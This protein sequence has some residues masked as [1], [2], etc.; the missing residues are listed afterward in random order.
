MLQLS[1]TGSQAKK[2][3]KGSRERV[4]NVGESTTLLT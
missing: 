3:R 1:G 4:F 2:E